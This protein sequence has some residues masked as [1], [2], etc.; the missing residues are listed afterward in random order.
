MFLNNGFIGH[1]CGWG[2][3][4]VTKLVIFCGRHKCMAPNHKQ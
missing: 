3:G 4:G 1:F 2:V